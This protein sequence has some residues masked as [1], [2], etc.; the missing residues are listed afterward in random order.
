M[1][2]GILHLSDIHFRRG[3]NPVL[4]RTEKI[5][6][7]FRGLSEPQLD[8][9]YVVVTG[10]IAYAGNEQE[11]SVAL[12]FFLELQGAMSEYS[13]GSDMFIFVP[14]NHDCEISR[15]STIRQAIIRDTIRGG[16]RLTDI[17]Q[18]IVNTCLEVQHEY[19]KFTSLFAGA[20]LTAKPQLYTA[21]SF[22]VADKTV[23][24]RCF[25]TAWMSELEEKQGRL[26][27]PIHLVDNSSD[28]EAD[29]IVTLLHHPFR[30]FESEN[31]RSFA[32]HVESNTDIILTGH[33][34]AHTRYQKF[35]FDGHTNQYIEGASLQKVDEPDSGFSAVVIDL[36][37]SLQ[38]S[39]TW[40]WSDNAYRLVGQ[41]SW[42][43]FL[44]VRR[45]SLLTNTTQ[46]AKQ[47][48]DLGVAFTHP[49]KETLVLE[50]LFIYPDLASL[51]ANASKSGKLKQ[52][53]NIVNSRSLI[54]EPRPEVLILGPER[55]GKTTLAKA[56]YLGFQN[57]GL[58]PLLI[59]GHTIP[60]RL[61]EESIKRLVTSAV[62][63]QYDTNL[64]EAYHQLPSTE[65]VLIVDDLQ[66]T[67]INQS[68][69]VVLLNYLRPRF[70][71]IVAFAHESFYLSGLT[72]TKPEADGFV[73]FATFML[74]E[75]GHRLRGALIDK[76]MDLGRDYASD[77]REFAIRVHTLETQLRGL[78]GKNLLPSYPLFVLTILQT[79]ESQ[80]ELNTASGSYGYYY[81]VLI[82][83]ALHNR[84]RSIPLDTIYT[85]L[86]A[87]AHKMF[88]EKLEHFSR[89]TF[90]AALESYQKKHKVSPNKDE[91]RRV[92]QEARILVWD[93]VGVGR[94][95]Y[96]YIYYYFVA[97]YLAENIYRQSEADEIRALVSRLS[98]TLYVE[99]HAN[100]I[101]FFLYLTK[102]EES[103]RTLLERTRTLYAESP[104]CNFESDTKFAQELI[105][106]LP[107]MMLE[108]GDT[109][110]HTER[111]R[112]ALDRSDDETDEPSTSEDDH[113]EIVTKLNEAFKTLQITGQV[114][115]NFPGSLE[116]E[117][118]VEIAKASYL[119]GLRV[120]GS[121]C[122][123]VG[124]N[125]TVLRDM[126]KDVL[127]EKGLR[128]E[129]KLE[130]AVDFVLYRI[131]SA[132]AFGVIKKVSHSLGSE[133]LA[134]TFEEVSDDRVPTSIS[135]VNLSIKLDHF[136]AFPL[137]D[138]LKVYDNAHK[139]LFTSSI[140]R[141]L[142]VQHLYLFPV[143]LRSRQTVCDRLNIR[144]EDPKLLTG[145]D[146]K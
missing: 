131:V 51:S 128:D 6:A 33:E 114:L 78:L 106:E 135:L 43:P 117:V 31:A 74:R 82:T 87:I 133:Y 67:K 47:L 77:D 130:Q 30:W 118:K 2:L 37:H 98:S 4:K 115:R 39:A 75:M 99:E 110:T 62:S 84:T 69:Q 54:D 50:D 63:E 139:N 100:I 58:K 24:F 108:D 32:K 55:S 124:L 29:L 85:F 91:V 113:L 26:F 123:L 12:D 120:L 60:R 125:I 17:D 28:S 145:E 141:D 41:P 83:G 112:S 142:V 136:Q 143:P 34:H 94:F 8:A 121:F 66:D 102:D 132:V 35:S 97:K 44:R 134:E 57:S 103:I 70:G 89:Q 14:G 19:F 11:Y 10:D 49:R 7:A 56:L 42:K 76:W 20:E 59:R 101:I 18:E 105:T 79:Y 53:E 88:A 1:K 92:L 137:H 138:I 71:K 146:R 3:N 119:L 52:T 111:H 144:I 16:G 96:K 93:E 45:S 5:V 81:E 116:G 68:G 25:N 27:F 40:R 65:K 129:K 90:D 107:P 140:V 64:V 122:K 95:L 13:S 80:Q 22:D 127:K 72:Q 48:H 9:C 73:T 15:P 36:T 46:Y 126:F 61:S 104:P 23:L 86:G 21:R 109:K 38:Q